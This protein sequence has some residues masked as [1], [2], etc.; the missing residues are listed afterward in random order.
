MGIPK[1]GCA[2]SGGALEVGETPAQRVAREALEETEVASEA[3]ALVA[4]DGRRPAESGT[5][6]PFDH[7]PRALSSICAPLNEGQV[8]SAPHSGRALP[9]DGEGVGRCVGVVVG[10]DHASG[11][12]A[13][14]GRVK[15]HLEG[16]GR[17]GR[18]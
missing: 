15:A 12:R 8:D 5:V 18:H 11:P 7:R 3:V 13:Q 6:M 1:G 2:L 14:R 9:L 16:G 17:T 10:D 4:E